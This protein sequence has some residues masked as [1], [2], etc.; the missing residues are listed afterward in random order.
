MHGLG[1]GCNVTPLY[2]V[3]CSA[4]YACVYQTTEARGITCDMGKLGELGDMGIR[5][6]IHLY[7]V[8]GCRDASTTVSDN[9]LCAPLTS[10]TARIS[11]LFTPLFA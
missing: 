7:G 8:L 11:T 3:H 6:K 9:R 10:C 4:S 1:I 2:T 5:C